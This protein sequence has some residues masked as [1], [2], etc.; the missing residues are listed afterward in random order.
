M[1]CTRVNPLTRL[2]D[3]L[4]LASTVDYEYAANLNQTA[5]V[6]GGVRRDFRFDLRDQ[7]AATTLA[8]STTIFDYNADRLRVKKID[9]TTGETRYLYDQSSVLIEYGGAGVA[10]ATHH[11]Y[12]DG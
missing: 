10:Y 9:P 6:Q 7:I 5:R 3:N 12:D 4:T 2:Q 8:G 1:N 11:K